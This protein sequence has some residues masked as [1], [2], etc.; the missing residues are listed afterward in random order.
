MHK[1]NVFI[2]LALICIGA[3]VFGFGIGGAFSVGVW[4]LPSQAMLSLKI[5]AFPTVF[6]IGASIGSEVFQVGITVDWWLFQINL[7]RFLYLYIGPGVYAQLS[8]SFGIGARI[9]V[10]LQ[11]FI[12]DPFELF[13]ELAPAIG[14]RISDPVKIP[15]FGLQGAFGFRFWF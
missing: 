11:V 7:V 14:V 3:P 12:L 2:L 4:D 1:R 13:L 6:A 8:R 5:D 9:P 10:G 15:A